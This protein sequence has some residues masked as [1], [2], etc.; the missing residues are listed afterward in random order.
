[1]RVILLIALLAAGS[2]MLAQPSHNPPLIPKP[3]AMVWNE[4][5]FT[6]SAKTKIIAERREFIADTEAFND[7]LKNANRFT[8]QVSRGKASKNA[9]VLA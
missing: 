4:G 3:A 5:V 7:L 1:M 9:I 8:L 6:L 2:I